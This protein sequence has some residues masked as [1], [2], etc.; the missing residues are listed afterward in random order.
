LSE[1]C[2][3]TIRQALASS[4]RRWTPQREAVFAAL[5]RAGDSHPTAED[6][7]RSVQPDVPRISLATVYNALEALTESG[8]VTRLAGTDGSARFDARHDRHYHLRCLRSGRV[9]DLETQYDP[10]LVDKLDPKLAERLKSQGF[11]LT[12]YRLE[13]VGYYDEEPTP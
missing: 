12:G 10:E 3:E 13:L 5:L 6:V 8:L 1:D 11:N 4:G 7:F 2:N 9:A